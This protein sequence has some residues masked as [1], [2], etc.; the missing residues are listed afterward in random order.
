MKYLKKKISVNENSSFI[1]SLKTSF[2]KFKKTLKHQFLW[3]S[4]IWKSPFSDPKK[5]SLSL[6]SCLKL[7]NPDLNNV[8]TLKSEKSSLRYLKVN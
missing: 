1:A 3:W 6:S 8:D 4:K 5:I 7:L 2:P